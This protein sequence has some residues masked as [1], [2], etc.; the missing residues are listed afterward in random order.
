MNTKLLL[1]EPSATMRHVLEDYAHS[2]GYEVEAV[3]EYRKAKDALNEQFRAFEGDYAGVLLGWPAV[4]DSEADEFAEL[5]EQDGFTDLPVVV[6]STDMRSSTRAWVAGRESTSLLSWKEYRNIERQLARM[7]TTNETSQ[8]EINPKF[9]N[10]DIH[11]LVVDDSISIR[12]ALRDMF[13]L[14]GYRVTLAST[15]D[16]AVAL[17]KTHQMDLAILDFYLQDG[18]GDVLCRE[19]THDPAT[20]NITCAMLTGTYS[21]HIIKRSL[22]AG[23]VECMFKN[24]SSELILSRVDAL[25]RII[26]QREALINSR[27]SLD[28][29]VD[30]LAG[31]TLLVDGKHKISYASP[32]ALGLLNQATDEELIGTPVTEFVGTTGFAGETEQWHDVMWSMPENNSVPLRFRKQAIGNANQ[33]LLYLQERE[34][35][36]I[37]NPQLAALDISMIE[38]FPR[39]GDFIECLGG[40]LMQQN[41]PEGFVSV[42]LVEI[43]NHDQ[44]LV[45]DDYQKLEEEL[46][47]FYK[48]PKHM[49]RIANKRLAFILRHKTEPEAYLMT[50]KLMQLCNGIDLPG[51][52]QTQRSTGCVVG[53]AN[54]A[55]LSSSELLQRVSLG[56][57]LVSKRGSDQALLLDVRKMLPVYPND[58]DKSSEIS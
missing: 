45:N 38:S 53:L 6:M 40:Y 55:A 28:K 30:T 43:D 1:V 27:I 19:L 2:L 15:H 13:E 4:P 42:L 18:S 57:D 5:L 54:N 26:R 49:A 46:L 50:R 29:I 47:G 31:A 14:Q 9:D 10:S 21:D 16:E 44:N 22:R 39:G 24:E 35:N 25:S 51:H 11:L 52:D 37:A 20:G 3:E 41:D 7:L 48:L 34:K 33:I 32:K 58:G 56:L 12:Y 36:T 17:A 8:Q 23:A